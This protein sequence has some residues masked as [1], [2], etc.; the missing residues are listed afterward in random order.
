MQRYSGINTSYT[1]L[2]KYDLEYN[3]GIKSD[4][5]LDLEYGT[6]IHAAINAHFEGGDAVSAFHM[7]WNV[8]DPNAAKSRFGYAELK[9]I[10]ERHM[11]K[12]VRLHSAKYVPTHTEQKLK[13]TIAGIPFEGTRDYIGGY[14]EYKNVLMDWKTTAYPY[15]KRKILVDEQLWLYAEAQYQNFGTYPEYLGYAPFV[16]D[17]ASIQTPIL[18]QFDLEKHKKQIDNVALVA[19][20]LASRTQFPKNKRSCLK[21]GGKAC[22]FFN[23]CYAGEI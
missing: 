16:K 6:A 21:S 5:G 18:M 7:A 4:K 2:T 15:D 8:V 10:G 13:Y 9:D 3:Q 1:C 19:V 23:V 20:D 12:W 22:E 17:G 14:C 11:T